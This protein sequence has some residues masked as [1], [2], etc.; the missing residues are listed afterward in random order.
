MQKQEIPPFTPCHS[1][2]DLALNQLVLLQAISRR[3]WRHAECSLNSRTS[4][5][6]VHSPYLMGGRLPLPLAQTEPSFHT[7]QIKEQRRRECCLS[8]AVKYPVVSINGPLPCGQKRLVPFH[9][10]CIE[11]TLRLL[12]SV[13]FPLMPI[14]ISFNHPVHV[15]LHMNVLQ[16]QKLIF[17]F[18]RKWFTYQAKAKVLMFY[19]LCPSGHFQ[20]LTVSVW[21]TWHQFP[22]IQRLIAGSMQHL[23]LFPS[24]F[25]GCNASSSE[26]IL[27][28]NPPI[29][30]G[31]P[32]DRGAPTL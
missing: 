28:L 3:P 8:T 19:I 13:F 11:V 6:S 4:W 1:G 9:D 29:H 24:D 17:F 27:D 18:F 15:C 16:N 32:E 25:Q 31:S 2:S 20:H 26:T 12:W 22:V 23:C 21:G 7:V 10:H 30:M 14:L 5:T